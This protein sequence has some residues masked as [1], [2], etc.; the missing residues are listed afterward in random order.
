MENIKDRK[1][2]RILTD[3]GG[4]FVNHQ[5]KTLAA[6]SSFIH[7]VSPPY[8]PEHN[9]FAERANQT[10]LEKERCLLLMSNLPSCY[11][12]EAVNTATH[13]VNIIPKLSRNNQSPYFLWTGVSPKIQMIRTF[14]CK[15]IFPIPRHQQSSKLAPTGEIGILLGFTNESAYCILKLNNKKVYT[16]PNSMTSNISWNNFLKEEEIYYDCLEETVEPEPI[17]EDHLEVERPATHL[18]L[19]DTCTYNKALKSETSATW[20]EAVTKELENMKKLYAWEEVPIN[21]EYKLIGSTWVLKTNRNA[22]HEILEHKARLCAQDFSQ[23]PGIDFSKT[24]APTGRLNSLQTLISHAASTGLK[25]EQLGNKS[26]FLNAPLEDK[27][28]LA[29]PQGLDCNKR[30]VCL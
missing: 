11:W 22:K 18:T 4:E 29:I 17:N 21:E 8:T 14:G 6:K 24:F 13:L 19:S 1:I 16:K 5:F 30:N 10:I 25:S 23:T 20:M 9:S 27:V 15:A 2:K 7:S 28:Y 12:A 3:G 26:P